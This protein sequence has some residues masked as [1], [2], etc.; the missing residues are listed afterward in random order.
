MASL[1]RYNGS[2]VRIAPTIVSMFP[3]HRRYV[4]VF[5]GTGAVLLQKQPMHEE[6]YNDIN[7]HVVNVF[8][9]L[10]NPE[11]RKRLIELVEFTPYARAEFER[12]VVHKDDLEKMD[13]VNRAHMFLILSIMAFSGMSGVLRDLKATNFSAKPKSVSHSN[14]LKL[15][16]T[17]SKVAKRFK[18]VLIEQ[19]VCFDLIDRWDSPETLFYADPPYMTFGDRLYDHS[20]TFAQHWKLLARLNTVK[21][22]VVLSGYNSILYSQRLKS[23]QRTDIPEKNSRSQPRTECIW[24]NRNTIKRQ[25]L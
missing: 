22:M 9:V 1:F 16:V 8:R 21:G 12:A 5:G 20:M 6:I 18:D 11:Q 19:C 25:F 4:E 14:W 13:P 17:I 23:W 2:K 24:V 3:H 10:Q 7:G 15:P